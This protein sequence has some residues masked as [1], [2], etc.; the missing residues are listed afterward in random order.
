MGLGREQEQEAREELIGTILEG[1][2][3]H[4][5]FWMWQPREG[6]NGL[7]ALLGFYSSLEA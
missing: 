6:C 5:R 3:L 1:E 4:G 7:L 2:A